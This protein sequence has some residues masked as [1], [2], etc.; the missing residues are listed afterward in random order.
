MNQSALPPRHDARSDSTLIGGSGSEVLAIVKDLVAANRILFRH[1]VVDAF[2]HVSARHPE[3]ADTFL[4]SYRIAPA[5]VAPE[6]IVAIDFDGQAVGKVPQS[7][8]LER[9]IHAEIYRAR[10]DVMAV[11]HSHSPSVLPFTVVP[12]SPLRPLCH[13]SGFL[14]PKAPV[15]EIRDAAGEGSDLLISTSSLGR[16]LAKTLAGQSVVLMRGHGSTVVGRTVQEAVFQAVYTEV[17]AQLQQQAHSLG[18][19]V[20]LTA[21]EAAACVTSVASNISRAWNLWLEQL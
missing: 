12:T 8:Y 5:L 14:H 7:L 21:D 17:N 13:M 6:H 15:F 9:Y 4:I 16:A 18:P 10:P 20:F 19:P 2:G 11:V 3:R 1:K